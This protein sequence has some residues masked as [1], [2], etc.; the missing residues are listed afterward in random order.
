MA[1]ADRAS[2]FDTW[3]DDYER[4]VADAADFP[5]AGY[6]QM[7]AAV[8]A[9][10]SGLGPGAAL[11]DLGC[12]TGNL[13]ARLLAAA[14]KA[15]L[16]GVEFS[17]AM[18]AAARAALP[19]ARFEPINLDPAADWVPLANRRFDIVAST[20][21]LH[22]FPDPA[23]LAILA[24][25][26]ANHLRPNGLIAVGDVSFPNADARAAAHDR[27][28]DRWDPDEH[29]W[30][31]SEILA[32]AATAGLPGTYRQISSCAGVYRFHPTPGRLTPPA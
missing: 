30:A 20:Y 13:A 16:L 26:A 9:T 7:L 1:R 2:L 25:L 11:V 22:G 10:A 18:L 21:L 32:A 6:D 28:R 31:A 17:P 15:D 3:A 19:A 5:F 12:G 27:F 24:R 8:A 4:I 29:Y 14:P 23:K